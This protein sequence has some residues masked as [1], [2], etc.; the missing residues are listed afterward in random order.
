MLKYM[1]TVY[2]VCPAIS[3]DCTERNKCLKKYC[4]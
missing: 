4:T 1:Y 3:K 2:K